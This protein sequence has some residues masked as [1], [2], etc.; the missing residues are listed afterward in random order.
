MGS[1]T[2]SRAI[3][4]QQSPL[5]QPPL[6]QPPLKQPPLKQPPLPVEKEGIL[7]QFN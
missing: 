3:R 2:A 4:T 1:M 7:N 5:K 6:K